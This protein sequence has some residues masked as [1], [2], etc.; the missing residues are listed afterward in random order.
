MPWERAL[1]WLAVMGTHSEGDARVPAV[2]EESRSQ[3][4]VARTP[5]NR[6]PPPDGTMNTQDTLPSEVKPDPEDTAQGGLE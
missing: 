4:Q 5:E 2:R 1:N 3:G 6:T